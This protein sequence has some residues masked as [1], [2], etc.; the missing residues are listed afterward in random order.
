MTLKKALDFC[1]DVGI[2][3]LIKNASAIIVGFSGGA[4]SAVLL[5]F[6]DSLKDE[7]S[8]KKIIAAH[9]NH[10]IRGVE[11]DRDEAFCKSFC[12]NLGIPLEIARID[13]PA[14]CKSLGKGTEEVARAERYAFFE[15]LSKKYPDSLIATAHNADDNLETVIF[16]IARGSGTKGLSGIAPVRDKKFIRP[17]L[18]CTSEEIRSFAKKTGIDYV[19]DSTNLDTVYTRNSIRH[20][21]SPLL[22]NLNPRVSDA[23]LRLSASARLDCDFIEKEAERIL[24]EGVTR[25]R[26]AKL[27]P[28][29][30]QR[31]ILSLFKQK[32]GHTCD[33][34]EKNI[35]DCRA[36]VLSKKSGSISLAGGL[37]FFAD[38]N[39]VYID[40]DP[41]YLSPDENATALPILLQKD[42]PLYFSDFCILL[43]E[44]GN[45]VN[46]ID[47]NVYKLSLHERL[48]CGKIDGKLW[49][50]PRRAGD[51][52]RKGNMTKKLKKLLCDADVPV[53]VRDTLPITVDGSGI[54]YVPYVGAR[55]GAVPDKSTKKIINLYI[56]KKE[57]TAP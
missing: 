7:L 34:S 44:N 36:L 31:V 11:A 6:F 2:L 5:S 45:Y 39:E 19:T 47:E 43:S 38:K 46:V 10:M 27:H 53:K 22:Y 28:A 37:A 40:T 55:D 23:A 30:F 12:E 3:D 26:L 20:E 49:I 18:S 1:R 41:K 8:E 42:F 14:L 35:K 56:F 29:L 24:Y 15:E 48:D 21:I 54:I 16:H 50:R 33:L 4:D 13:I 57:R 52:I 9:V 51:T 17:L 32:A 25:E